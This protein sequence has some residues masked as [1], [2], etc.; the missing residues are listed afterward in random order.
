MRQIVVSKKL[1]AKIR[2]MSSKDIPLLVDS[3]SNDV[4]WTAA[5]F[6]TF[7]KKKENVILVAEVSGY[8][9]GFVAIE[10]TA[11]Y[12]YIHQIIVDKSLRRHNIG[13]QLLQR[14]QFGFLKSNMIC[15]IVV[16]EK[17]TGLQIFLRSCGFKAVK[18]LPAFF[19]EDTG[20]Y[21]EFKNNIEDLDN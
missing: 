9:V 10:M 19:E 11:D 1:P 3:C 14:I 2:W 12:I 20:Y 13:S 15:Q 6:K 4:N 5:D 21:F 16:N 17:N 8:A 7:I 18:I